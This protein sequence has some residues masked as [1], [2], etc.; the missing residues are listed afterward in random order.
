MLW[1]RSKDSKS[2]SGNIAPGNYGSGNYG[3]GN[4]GSGSYGSGSYGSGAYTNGGSYVADNCYESAY[5]SPN[6]VSYPY[7][8]SGHSSSDSSQYSPQAGQMQ[9]YYSG[10]ANNQM[11]APFGHSA[12]II[13]SKSSKRERV[14][15]GADEIGSGIM[16][17]G[18][19]V[20]VVS[21]IEPT[22]VAGTAALLTTAA[23]GAL[24]TAVWVCRKCNAKFEEYKD[25]MRHRSGLCN[26]CLKCM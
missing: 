26:G 2:T 17:A 18:Q 11:S 6:T 25:N 1:K 16:H 19:A 10:P 23:G 5:G 9:Q 12:D 3:S 20:S 14:L 4:Y 13:P 21:L 24:K 8:G 15:D 7:G 22:G